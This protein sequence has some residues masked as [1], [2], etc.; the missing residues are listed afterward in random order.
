MVLFQNTDCQRRF[1]IP[2]SHSACCSLVS[3]LADDDRNTWNDW[4]LQILR[5]HAYN[6]ANISV[7]HTW[8]DKEACCGLQA[9]KV[10]K[11]R[12]DI[13]ARFEP[14]F[15]GIAKDKPDCLVRVE[16]KVCLHFPV[17]SLEGHC[18]VMLSLDLSAVEGR[19]KHFA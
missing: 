15:Q 5:V 10:H 17:L 7:Q 8:V 11:S 4:E 14:L 2:R 3:S 18:D 6:S 13:Y 9:K 19:H 12:I 16:S 1:G